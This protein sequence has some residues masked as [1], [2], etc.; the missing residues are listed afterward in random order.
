VRGC[1]VEILV[2]LLL[3]CFACFSQDAGASSELLRVDECDT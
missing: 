3:G 2:Y 1:W